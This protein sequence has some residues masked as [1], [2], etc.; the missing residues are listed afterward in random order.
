MLLLTWGN[1]YLCLQRV[2]L[3]PSFSQNIFLYVSKV[4]QIGWVAPYR[5]LVQLSAA[6]C[7]VFLVMRCKAVYC[8]V[9]PIISSWFGL[10][11]S[12][13]CPSSK[14]VLCL[15]G[16]HNLPYS[17]QSEAHIY[18]YEM[19]IGKYSTNVIIF[20]STGSTCE[21]KWLNWKLEQ[22]MGKEQAQIPR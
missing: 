17:S 6:I 7:T 4:R 16:I 5:M 11:W 1:I 15:S 19:T 20:S 13:C 14:Y 12:E 21:V 10:H 22:K 2:D 8:N 18:L 3:I 9:S